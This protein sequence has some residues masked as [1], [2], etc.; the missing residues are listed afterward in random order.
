MIDRYE[1]YKRTDNGTHVENDP[2]PRDVS[3][4]A[5]LRRIRHHDRALSSPQKSGANTEKRTC[6]DN[7]G[8]V[9]SMRVAQERSRI[10][11]I[12]Q[13][14]NRQ[15]QAKAQTIGKSSS[16]E[17][18]D[19]KG[20]VEGRVCV[21]LGLI[22]DLATTTEASEGVEH[23]GTQEADDGD[24]EQLDLGRG[25]PKLETTQADGFVHPSFGTEAGCV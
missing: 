16:E 2:E 15:S 12:S 23:A 17:T 11:T 22:G 19:G 6:E 25:I 1:T 3:S 8:H 21:I 9:L 14:S 7:K 10:N 24:H 13:S 18:N 5:L 4:F 20:A